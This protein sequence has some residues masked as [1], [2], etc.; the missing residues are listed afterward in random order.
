[1]KKNQITRATS[2]MYHDHPL[3]RLVARSLARASGSM[4]LLRN[5][6]ARGSA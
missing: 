4:A 5:Q 6:C 2:A 3:M 1:M